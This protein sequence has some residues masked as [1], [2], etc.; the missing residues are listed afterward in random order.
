MLYLIPTPLDPSAALHEQAQKML[1]LAS[2]KNVE[3]SLFLMEE[4][5]PSRRRW[6]QWGLPRECI[7]NFIYFN[8]QT[9][10]D[11]IQ[12]IIPQLKKGKTAYL[13]SDGGLPAFCDPGRELVD[14]CHN[15]GIRVSATAFCNSVVLALAL[16]G[17]DCEPFL[18]SGFIPRDQKLRASW[19]S[20]F[21]KTDMCTAVMDTAYRLPKVIG[22]LKEADINGQNRYLIAM[23]LN[24]ET[25]FLLRGN[26]FEIEKRYT[27]SKSDF[28]LIKG[29]Y[30]K[31]S[32]SHNQVKR[33]ARAKKV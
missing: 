17:F 29:P 7:E 25:E 32:T 9:S 27:G 26:I 23:D 33:F 2:T 3:N 18:F 1:E 6:L 15:E 21:V 30:G 12:K 13:M 24:R 16:S 8:E 10:S 22:E 28:I 19:F 4:P 31:S 20:D 5:K 14:R 11:L